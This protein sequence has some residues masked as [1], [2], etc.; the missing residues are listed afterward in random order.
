MTHIIKGNETTAFSVAPESE[1]EEI[2][3][4]IRLLL[5]SE[6]YE[7]PLARDMGLSYDYRGRPIPV[8]KTLLYQAIFDAVEEFEPR[9]EIV[10]IDFEEDSD[11][12]IIIPIVEVKTSDG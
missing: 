1:D 10:N 11:K 9:A 2:L 5:S 4:N 12:G 6:K 3:Q 7:L 8:A